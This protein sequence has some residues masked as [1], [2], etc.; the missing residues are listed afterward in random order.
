MPAGG[1]LK[2]LVVSHFEKI[3]LNN[4]NEVVFALRPLPLCVGFFARLGTEIAE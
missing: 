4:D 1:F 2:S 3:S